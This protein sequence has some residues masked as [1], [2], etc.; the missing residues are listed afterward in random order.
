[1]ALVSE[2]EHLPFTESLMPVT[3]TAVII[4]RA[5]VC[6]CVCVCVWVCARTRTARLA[7]LPGALT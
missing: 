7:D 1:M 4:V 3:L 5:L 6:V 2:G